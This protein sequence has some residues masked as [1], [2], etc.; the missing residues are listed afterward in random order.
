VAIPL[1]EGAEWLTAS[2]C[3]TKQQPGRIRERSRNACGRAAAGYGGVRAC[4]ADKRA[5]D[6]RGD[7]KYEATFNQAVVLCA[8]KADYPECP[9][10]L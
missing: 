1:Q 2:R 9:S 8:P 4:E 7:Q 5:P 6:N 10:P 3:G